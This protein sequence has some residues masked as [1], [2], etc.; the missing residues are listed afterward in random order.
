M[1][2]IKLGVTLIMDG[3]MDRI[4]NQRHCGTDSDLRFFVYS[5]S[6]SPKVFRRNN[7]ID[8]KPSKSVLVNTKMAANFR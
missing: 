5:K 2:K 3:S 8:H 7:S 1:W 4:Q 6:R